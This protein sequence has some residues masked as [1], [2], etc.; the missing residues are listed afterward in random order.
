MDTY[1]LAEAARQLRTSSPRIRRAV[2]RLGLPVQQA[3]PGPRGAFPRPVKS[4]GGLES[5]LPPQDVRW[6]AL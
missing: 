3:C 5:V 2:D 1:S 4:P 6:H